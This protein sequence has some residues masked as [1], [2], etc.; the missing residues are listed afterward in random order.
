[1]HIWCNDSLV[2]IHIH[3]PYTYWITS[4]K[5]GNLILLIL[6]TH[7]SESFGWAEFEWNVKTCLRITKTLYWSYC[8]TE[9]DRNFFFW[10]NRPNVDW[11]EENLCRFALKQL[12][13]FG[14]MMFRTSIRVLTSSGFIHDK[15]QEKG[16]TIVWRTLQV[17]FP[18]VLDC[19][20]TE[21]HKTIQYFLDQSSASTG[22][23]GIQCLWQTRWSFLLVTLPF[24][25]SE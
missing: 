22:S 17:E 13:L 5:K 24:R 20:V 12:N 16:N 15:S 7:A 2:S 1:M 23:C 11:K 9:G 4:L 21:P 18:G 10:L 6:L 25:N 14:F 3:H 8:M 19:V